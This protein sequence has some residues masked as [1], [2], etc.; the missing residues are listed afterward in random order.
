M[1]RYWINFETA[2]NPK[3]ILIP[4]GDEINEINNGIAL[5]GFYITNDSTHIYPAF[6]AKRKNYSDIPI[7]KSTG[8][9]TYD[10]VD[11]KY[12]IASKDKLA[13]FNLPGNYVSLHKTACNMYGEGQMNLGVNFDRITTTQ[14]GS[15]N[16]D[17][18]SGNQYIEML[19][20]LR[21]FIVDKCIE[22][23]AKDIN[24]MPG[25]E[26]VDISRPVFEKGMAEILG[27]DKA[28]EVLAEFSL[29]R[30]K[31]MS[32]D[33]EH[34]LLINDL[35]LKWKQATKSYISEGQIGIGIIGKDYVNRLVSGTVEIVKKRSGD[36]ITI[37][38]EL[39]E[40]NWYFFSYT[41]GVL[42]AASSNESFMAAINEL[43]PEQRKLSQEK[44]EKPYSFYPVSQTIKNKFIKHIQ[45]VKAGEEVIEEPD[46]VDDK[47][48]K[49][50]E[51]EPE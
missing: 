9:L 43:K 20:G 51:D 40:V 14:V 37:Y 31:K 26:P 39:D 28:N 24:S 4:I 7:V 50:K 27:Q 12:K 16:Y 17:L 21:F 33:L 18:I 29:G 8:F 47:G 10:K 19:L 35:T 22:I 34:T 48:K 13:E 1:D 5:A 23:M 49:P 44:N 2:I 45:S 6:L 46:D 42:Q 30:M 15:M 11:G 41:R 32:K 36:K 25:L 3:E 38:L